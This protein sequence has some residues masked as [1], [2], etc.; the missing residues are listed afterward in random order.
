[1][2]TDGIIISH[3]D[4]LVLVLQV[5][6]QFLKILLDE[7]PRAPCNKILCLKLVVKRYVCLLFVTRVLLVCLW[8]IF[9]RQNQHIFCVKSFL[10]F[11]YVSVLIVV[12]EDG[13]KYHETD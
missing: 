3:N 10:L 2:Q 13:E 4:I 8:V 9:Y 12:Y 1:M 5:A 7:F 6:N 11:S